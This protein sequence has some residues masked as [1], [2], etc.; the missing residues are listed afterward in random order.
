[1]K[2]IPCSPKYFEW[3]KKNWETHKQVLENQ[4]SFDNTSKKFKIIKKFIIVMDGKNT[5]SGPFNTREA[6][7]KHLEKIRE[8]MLKLKNQNG[9]GDLDK[10][11]NDGDKLEIKEVELTIEE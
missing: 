3:A 6:A 2:P 8:R 9:L 7:Q 11:M 1:M 4:L 5:L 10:L